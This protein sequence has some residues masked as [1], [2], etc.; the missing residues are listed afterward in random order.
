MKPRET[1]LRITPEQIASSPTIACDC[2]SKLFEEGMIF[3]K[4]SPIISPTGR[5]E[6]F[7]IQVVLCKGCGKIPSIFDIDGVIPKE[8]LATKKLIN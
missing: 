1:Q 2:G 7:P 6:V 3:K 8:L 4:L 5:E